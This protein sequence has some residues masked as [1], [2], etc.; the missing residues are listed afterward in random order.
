M[1]PVPG[2]RRPAVVGP[3]RDGTA[4]GG[5]TCVGRGCLRGVRHVLAFGLGGWA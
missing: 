5:W 3:E 2:C 1:A 4:A